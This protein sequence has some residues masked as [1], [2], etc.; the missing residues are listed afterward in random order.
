MIRRPPRST[1][2]S[3]HDA[4]PISAGEHTTR[5]VVLER[6]GHEVHAVGE[7]RRGERVPGN[8]SVGAP[9]EAEMQPAR[10][11]DPPALRCT[12]ALTHRGTGAAT[13][14]GGSPTL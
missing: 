7:Q 4:L 13:V 3:L 11:V 5:A 14:G 6:A 1:L 9:V 12:Q 2:F 10:T 8:T